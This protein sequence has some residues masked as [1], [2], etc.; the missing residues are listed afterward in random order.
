M[1]DTCIYIQIKSSNESCTVHVQYIDKALQ[2]R[3]VYNYMAKALQMMDVHCTG[4]VW[5]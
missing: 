4:T 5:R 1:R 2:I 3:D